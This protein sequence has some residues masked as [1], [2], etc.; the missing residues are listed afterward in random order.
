MKKLVKITLLFDDGEDISFEP[1]FESFLSITRGH[2]T[3]TGDILNAFPQVEPNGREVMLFLNCPA[4]IKEEIV[5]AATEAIDK[6]IN[7]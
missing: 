2:K 6:L 1:K 3:V 4:D 5:K 7:D